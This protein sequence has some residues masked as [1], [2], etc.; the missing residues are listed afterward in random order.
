MGCERESLRI[1]GGASRMALS[2][3]I[4]NLV[5]YRECVGV[6]A[7]GVCCQKLGDAMFPKGVELR[8]QLRQCRKGLLV[9]MLLKASRL[10]NRVE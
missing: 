9:S 7:C 1:D 8:E 6:A 2:P 4:A 3:V 10:A 5:C